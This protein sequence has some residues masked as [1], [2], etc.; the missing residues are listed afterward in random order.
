MSRRWRGGE[1]EIMRKMGGGG[2]GGM[3]LE[4]AERDGEWNGDGD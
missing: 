4:M 3:D 2:G 1:R